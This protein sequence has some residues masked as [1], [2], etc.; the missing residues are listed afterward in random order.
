MSN[1]Y[2]PERR[3]WK[4]RSYKKGCRQISEVRE[5]PVDRYAPET[6]TVNGFLYVK[7]L[8]PPAFRIRTM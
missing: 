4:G 1:H 2:N 3:A 5:E 8:P 7:D 6:E